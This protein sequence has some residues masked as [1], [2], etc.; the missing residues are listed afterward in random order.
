MKVLY[1]GEIVARPG[2]DVVKEVLPE[3]LKEHKPDLV[4]ANAENIYG[5]R[6]IEEDR[7]KQMQLLGIDYFT[8]GDHAFDNRNTP[9][10]ID[11]L[12]VLRP[13]NM[14]GDLP[15]KGYDVIDLGSKGRVLLINLMGQLFMNTTADNPFHAADKILEL[16][17]AENPDFT[18]I[19]FHAEATSE[20][21]AMGFYL[22][23][24]INAI[25]GTH[26]H[27]PTADERTLPK[28]TLAV[29]DLGMCGAIDSI[30]GVQKDIIIDR[31]LGLEKR[32]FEWESAGIKAFR[33]VLLDLENKTI[34]RLD[35][36]VN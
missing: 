28:G 30:L 8:T 7:V 32:R 3:I 4:L 13:A 11:N 33:S 15:G 5:G 23:G 1:V 19:D 2:R 17:K 31:F 12:P 34:L 6:G 21:H 20:K 16:K 36:I 10:F 22:D 25:V 24:R 26:T 18:L 27:V 9:D 14:P 35:K 29:S